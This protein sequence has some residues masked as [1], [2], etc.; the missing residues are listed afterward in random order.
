MSDRK[1]LLNI[2]PGRTRSRSI[3]SC[4]LVGLS[5]SGTL[6]AQ[7]SAGHTV[8]IRIIRPILFSIAPVE[9]RFQADLRQKNN[10]LQLNWKSDSKPKKI[11]VSRKSDNP[12]SKMDLILYG[13]GAG[14]EGN[15]RKSPSRLRLEAVEENLTGAISKTAGSM[16][17]K[18]DSGSKSR[19]VSEGTKERI[20]Y[21]VCDI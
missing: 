12:G 14:S 8:T 13:S 18:Y 19:G 20:F 10:G 15:Q 4:L 21:T 16:T 6:S 9:N 11:T 5:M 7:Q 1:K 2:L 17:M 3:I